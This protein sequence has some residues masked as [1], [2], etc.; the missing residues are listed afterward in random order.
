MSYSLKIGH[1]FPDI[2]NM[3]G[4]KGN[5]AALKNRMVWR[6]YDLCVE[7][8]MTDDDFCLN[9]FDIV[10]L[11]GGSEKDDIT[12]CGILSSKKDKIKE[13]IEN[14]GVWL[15]LCGGFP[16]LGNFFEIKNEKIEGLGVLDIDSS[17]DERFIG[18]V[19]IETEIFGE[20]TTVCGFENHSHRT[21]IKNYTP[22]G[23]V[24]KGN[25]NNGK[26]G[27]CGV[28]YKNLI[29]SFLHGPLLPKNPKLCDY[30]LSKAILKKYG[31][32][33]NLSPLDD[34]LEQEAHDYCVKR[35]SQ[36]GEE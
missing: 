31:E 9:D 6:G 27:K 28:I 5:I 2:L 10:I 21:D 3:F 4:D 15:S 33:P 8:I 19:I 34:T 35:F 24:I 16:M 7:E 17:Y 1:L 30:I 12:A 11:G 26:D 36:N 20:K 29:G 18:N 23:R 32:T 22:F 14:G 25:G 13:Y